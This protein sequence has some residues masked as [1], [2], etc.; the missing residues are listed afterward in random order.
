MNAMGHPRKKWT[1]G[2]IRTHKH[3]IGQHAILTSVEGHNSIT[4]W[5]KITGNNPNL[6]NINAHTKFGKILSISS[7]DIE[8]KQKS[9][10]NSD[11]S[12]GP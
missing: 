12:Q 9:E 3:Y 8:R 11:I 1:L 7:Q 5:R 4:N 10:L 2:H 6:V